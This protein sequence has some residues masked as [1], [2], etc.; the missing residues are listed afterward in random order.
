MIKDWPLYRTQLDKEWPLRST[1][2]DKEWPLLA[3]IGQCP[4]RPDYLGNCIWSVSLEI[5]TKLDICFS[6]WYQ[7]T[8]PYIYKTLNNTW[9]RL[10]FCLN[11]WPNAVSPVSI[12]LITT[13]VPI[14]TVKPQIIWK[15]PQIISQH[16]QKL[17]L[18]ACPSVSRQFYPS[19]YNINEVTY[20]TVWNVR[21]LMALASRTK[22]PTF[23]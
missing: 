3:E 5:R 21:V 16:P 4:R 12:S 2:V 9:A 6:G 18:K 10:Y 11:T 8:P 7:A 13:C 15:L 20:S 14:L 17:W 22:D 23:L 1:Q 19:S